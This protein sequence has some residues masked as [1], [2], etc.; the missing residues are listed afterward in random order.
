M[1]A[2]APAPTHCYSCGRT[3]DQGQT[4]VVMTGAIIC[5]EC[6]DI[7]HKAIFNPAN[8]TL[9]A[10]DDLLSP[11]QIVARMD[12]Y[13]IGQ[14]EAKE[15]LAVAVYN[16]FKRL[17]LNMACPGLEFSKSNVLLIGPSGSGKTHLISTLARILDV[18][19]TIADAT[20]VTESGYVGDDVES[21]VMKLLQAAGNDIHRAQRG[22]IYIDEIDKISRK[23]DSSSI[24]RDVSGEGV[25]QALLK[26]VEGTICSFPEGGG[27]KNPQARMLEL[28]TRNILF[29]AGGA[30][31]GLD[32]IISRRQIDKSIGFGASV[33][34]PEQRQAGELFKDV[35]TDDLIAA[36]LIKEFVG[37][38]PVITTLEDLGEAAL[39]DILTKPKNALITQTVALAKADAVDLTF[40]DDAITAIARRA[41]KRKTGARGLRSIVEKITHST[42]LQIRALAGKRVHISTD[43][44]NGL[45][46]PEIIETDIDPSYEEQTRRTGTNG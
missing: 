32:K 42:T 35:Q 26:L 6:L 43:V 20:S 29:I 25:Q 31:D 46:E 10:V 19:F 17:R 24:T 41:L 39:V 1:S 5:S 3:E 16:H 34:P 37:R 15:T 2:N 45:A 27:R 33:A 22:I 28:D 23:G 14:T 44:V 4:L 12:E 18:P 40:S 11:D 9:P 7:A 21:I 36:G 8:P 13:V 30:F 38:F